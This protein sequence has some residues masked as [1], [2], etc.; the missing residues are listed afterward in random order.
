MTSRYMKNLWATLMIREMQI[1]KNTRYQ[2][3][4][5]S[6]IILKTMTNDMYWW[7][8][9][10]KSPYTLLEKIETMILLRKTALKFLKIISILWASNPPIE[11]AS[12]DIKSI[13]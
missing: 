10:K 13:Y 11:Y 2:I 4:C 7:W 6:V 3:I 1:K 9:D 8:C 5:D 12:K